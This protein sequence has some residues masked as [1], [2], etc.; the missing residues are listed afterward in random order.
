MKK[1][2]KISVFVFVTLLLLNNDS[3]A[4]KEFDDIRGTQHWMMF[5]D[6]SNSLYHYLAHQAYFYLDKRSDK[7]SKINSLSEWKQ[8]QQWIK[9]TL[10]ETVG[11]F[12][13]KTPLNAKVTKSF[14]EDNYHLENIVYQSQPGYYVTAGLFIPNGLKKGIKVPAIIYCSGHSDNGYRSGI[15]QHTILNLVEK[16]FI[17]FAFDPIGQGERLQYYNSETHK[18]IFKYPSYE[19]SYPGAQLFITG[20][21]LARNFI[22]DGIRAVDYLLT[23]KE[24]DP[25]RIGITG[26][27]GGGTQSAFIAA[28]DNR[29]KA[30]GA[31]N[32]FTN[33]TRLYESMGPQDAEQNFFYGIKRGLDMADLIEVHAP[34]P[35]LMIT[36][37]RDMFPIQGAIETFKE[38]SGIYKAYGK[39][40]NLQMV[41]DDAPH[42][43]TKKNREAMYAFFQRELSNPGDSTDVDVKSLS[44]E[45]LQ[46]TK[47][48][49]VSTSLNSETA[50]SLN[51]KDA[52]KKMQ[53][54]QTKR[55]NLPEYFSGIITSAKKLS[56]YQE[57]K[58]IEKPIFAGRIQRD[59]YVI[60]KY[61][62][63][64]EGK[65][66]IPYLLLKPETASGKALIYLNPK[67][68]TTDAGTGGQMEWFVKNGIAVLAPDMVGTGELGPGIFHGDSY[69]DS[70]SYNLW[71]ASMLIGRSIVGI[72]AADVVR[73]TNLLKEEYNIK[74]IYGLAKKQM[75]PVLLHA[76]AFDKDIKKIALVE[77]YSSYRSIVMNPHYNPDFLHSTVPGSIGIYDL[78]DLAASLAPRKLLLI[79]VTDG[80]SNDNN[81]I[82]IDK[83]LPVIKAAFQNKIK[84]KLQIIPFGTPESLNDGFK[85]WLEN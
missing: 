19:H 63:K 23:R 76:A 33:F 78:P 21:T 41:M 31:G 71:F 26:R 6:A 34:K 83:D 2:L 42:A 62:V 11:A 38:V 61:L 9:N 37:S 1:V 69:I 32:Y 46:V 12:P 77:P 53:D 44:P 54:L 35:I 4:Q 15:Y 81:T 16:G 43:S 14:N 51:Y 30:V 8:R 49:Q 73:L 36:T 25:E 18:S 48:G 24:V 58:E 65:Y 72:Q 17:V 13:S 7:I 10:K 29:I 50:C 79:G 22:W 5:S 80:N 68:K 57:P 45:E 59:G 64:G 60:E 70:V 20:N 40:E 84:D 47:T 82:D 85:E 39:P 67:G 3:N 75:S 56:G 27:S 66:M 55:K 28:F 74:E 52:E